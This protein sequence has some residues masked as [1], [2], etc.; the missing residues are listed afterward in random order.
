MS[1]Q[2]QA[3]N[4]ESRRPHLFEIGPAIRE[5]TTDPAALKDGVG[6]S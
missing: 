6:I 3:K 2:K 4:M 1:H 5:P